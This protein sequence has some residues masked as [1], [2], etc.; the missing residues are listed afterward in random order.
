M[1]TSPAKIQRGMSQQ[2]HTWRETMTKQDHRLGWKIGFNMQ[3]DQQR[4]SLPSAMVG[5]LSR[6]RT[7]LSG[8]HYQTSANAILLVEPEIAVQIHCDVPAG[9]SIEQANS[10][11]AAYTAALELIDTTR[12]V[13]DDIEAI[14]GGNLF[15]ESVVLA[16]S[17]ISPANYAREQLAFSLHL[18]GE[19]VR[20]L[21]QERVPQD[22]STLIIDTANILAEH[23]EQLQA[24]DWIITGAAAK[25][26]PVQAGDDISLDMQHLGQIT[27]NLK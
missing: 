17:R 21:E 13:G 24:G 5:Y 2:L 11:I 14:L 16:E 12:S 20:T 6:Q 23:G 3:A 26:V 1:P 27:L 19:E 25:P 15:H 18:N 22:F 9:A 7:L 8:Q 4:L 10:A